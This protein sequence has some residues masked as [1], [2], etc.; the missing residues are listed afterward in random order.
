MPINY[1]LHSDYEITFFIL[2]ITKVNK[3]VFAVENKCIIEKRIKKSH[4][5]IR[6]KSLMTKNGIMNAP[7]ERIIRTLLHF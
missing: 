7:L 1:K 6:K 4:G 5:A 2:T 3:A